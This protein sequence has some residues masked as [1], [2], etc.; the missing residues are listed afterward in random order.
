MQSRQIHR[1]STRKISCPSRTQWPQD[2]MLDFRAF[3]AQISLT[4]LTYNSISPIT[5]R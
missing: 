1:P 3:R 2:M 4:A 5:G